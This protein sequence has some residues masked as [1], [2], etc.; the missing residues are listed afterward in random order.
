MYTGKDL[1]NIFDFFYKQRLN[2]LELAKAFMFKF[3]ANGQKL[4]CEERAYDFSMRSMALHLGIWLDFLESTHMIL[5]EY[6]NHYKNT[7]YGSE[8]I[9]H[10]WTSPNK[11]NFE[12]KEITD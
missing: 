6:K 8:L 7:Q 1:D 3:A 12:E 2:S 11:F 4:I 5:S 10:Y 9:Q